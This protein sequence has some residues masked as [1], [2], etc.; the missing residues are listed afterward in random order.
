VMTNRRLSVQAGFKLSWSSAAMCGYIRKLWEL[1]DFTSHLFEVQ[2]KQI[3]LGTF[4]KKKV[5]FQPSLSPQGYCCLNCSQSV[6]YCLTLFLLALFLLPWRWRR[7]G[8]PKRRF[9]IN[10]HVATSQKT[11]FFVVTTMKTSNP[12]CIYHACSHLFSVKVWWLFRYFSTRDV[13]NL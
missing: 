12:T 7:H 10:P 3:M 4:F 11:A 6:G 13:I 8:P 5:T 1:K 2:V 9:I